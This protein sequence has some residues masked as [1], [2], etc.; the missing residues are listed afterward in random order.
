[1]PRSRNFPKSNI[2]SRNSICGETKPGYLCLI[3][4]LLSMEA[5]CNPGDIEAFF[6]ASYVAFWER[7]QWVPGELGDGR[8]VGT[9][10]GGGQV[11]LRTWSASDVIKREGGS[12]IPL[13]WATELLFP[14]VGLR[15]L[16]NLVGP[17]EWVQKYRRIPGR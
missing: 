9:E 4:C 16:S 8:E 5:F 15:W 2:R 11:L 12:G 6:Y 14:G 10:R 3:C 17:L 1:M 13:L 7:L